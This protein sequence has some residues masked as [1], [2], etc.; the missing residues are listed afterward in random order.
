MQE[1]RMNSYAPLYIWGVINL[2]YRAIEDERIINLAS[3]IQ[4]Y[5]VIV[6]V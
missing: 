3:L 2:L 1:G 4:P 6:Y 5:Y